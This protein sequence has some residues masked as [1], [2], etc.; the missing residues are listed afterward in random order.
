[1]SIIIVKIHVT[2]VIRVDIGK[3]LQGTSGKHGEVKS[4]HESGSTWIKAVDKITPDA[5]TFTTR[6]GVRSGFK[7]GIGSKIRV[8]LLLSH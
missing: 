7:N 6:D 5:N 4:S 3:T 1:M 2:M 8:T